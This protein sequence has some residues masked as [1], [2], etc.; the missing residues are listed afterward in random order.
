R[1]GLLNE[2]A[3]IWCLPPEVLTHIF[4]LCDDFRQGPRRVWH[5]FTVSHVCARWR[6]VALDAGPLWSAIDVSW[7][8]EWIR[9]AARRTDAT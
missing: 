6:K 7:G 3:P 2:R 8:D 5:W 4:S 1:R 9:E